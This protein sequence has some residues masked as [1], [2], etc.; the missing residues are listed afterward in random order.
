[1]GEPVK[2][3]DLARNM[4]K[5]SGYSL[6]D[7]KIEF[8]GI[9]P[10]EKMYEELLNEEEIHPEQIYP[11]IYIGKATQIEESKINN[12]IEYLLNNQNI[13]EELVNF[14]NDKGDVSNV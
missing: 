8:T 10:G 3:V 13:K 6:E 11:K 7:I 5:L 14:V 4:I 2:I 1:M 12:F 9:R